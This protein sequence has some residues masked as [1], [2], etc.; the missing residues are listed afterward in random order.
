MYVFIS[1]RRRDLGGG[2]W[3]IYHA[4]SLFRNRECKISGVRGRNKRAMMIEDEG[5]E[6]DQNQ[7]Q[8][9][10]SQRHSHSK[11]VGR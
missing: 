4:R 11:R 2:R 3:A 5:E 7:T 8:K 9:R 6:D 10:I 1:G